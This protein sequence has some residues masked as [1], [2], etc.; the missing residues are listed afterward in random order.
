MRFAVFALLGVAC[1]SHSAAVAPDGGRAGASGGN[2]T[3]AA[4]GTIGTGASSGSGAVAGST[5]ASST[6]T[7]DGD[8]SAAGASGSDGSG[9]ADASDAGPG[10]A[11]S[12]VPVTPTLVNYELTGTWPALTARSPMGPI[13]SQSGALTYTMI[14]VHDQF[15]AESCSI[16]DYNKD[17]IP[18]ISSG[19][20]WYEGP[21]FKTVHIFRGGHD[22][23]PRAGTDAELP[24]SMSDDWADYPVDVDGD[25]WPDIIDIANPQH[26]A[27]V[28]AAP[29]AQ[30]Y[31]SAYWYKNPGAP[32]NATD[33]FWTANL[34][35]KGFVMEEHGLVDV[36]GDGKPEV[37]G[38]CMNNVDS[39]SCAPGTA[40]PGTG[41]KGYYQADWANPTSPWTF[42]A[43][44]RGYPLP[45]SSGLFNG[46]GMGDLDGDGRPDFLELAGAWIQPATLPAA[47]VAWGGAGPQF[48]GSWVPTPFSVPPYLGTDNVGGDT[49]G[50]QMF[51]FDV[52]GDG[53]TDVISADAAYGW[54]LAWYQQMPPGAGA[55]LGAV[56]T[57]SSASPNCFVKHP[58]LD[59]NGMP[60]DG[61]AFSQ[62]HAVQLVDMDGDGLPDVVTGKTWLADRY[63]GPDSMA[64]PVV[65]VFKLV[66]EAN[67]PRAGMAH[68]EPHLVNKAVAVTPATFPVQWS[69]GSGVGRQIAIGQIN[70][71][72]DGI[73]DICV[74]SKLGL[75]VYL[76][77]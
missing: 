69:G 23:L 1:G 60:I 15:L 37:L 4:A 5:D 55:C 28:S 62:L 64:A 17:G 19:R 68:F 25:G 18:D 54:G 49:G 39:P 70:P 21:D 8:A 7:S 74:A 53:L 51:A 66:R 6:T 63:N 22:A 11:G 16:A 45:F 26:T 31:A 43:V 47:T 34:M 46:I 12:V 14:Q 65:Y 59:S 20:R 44:T 30:E 33:N 42:H 32:A 29:A 67:P 56:T 58:I 48:A 75:F 41:V 72:T 27:T 10:T 35:Q 73:M 77:Q 2:K 38:A 13:K 24:N 40:A 3:D 50:S 57:R 61:V 52:D 71:Q 9:M 36:D 76:G